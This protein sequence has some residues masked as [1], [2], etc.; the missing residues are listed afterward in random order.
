MIDL[1]RQKLLLRLILAH[2]LFN[3]RDVCWYYICIATIFLREFR[4]FEFTYA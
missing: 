1:E 2:L 4:F 3:D